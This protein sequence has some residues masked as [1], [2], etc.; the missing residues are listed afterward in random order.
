MEHFSKRKKGHI[1]LL[2]L[3]KK[4]KA[5]A[6]VPR[7][8]A[9]AHQGQEPVKPISKPPVTDLSE[10]LKQIWSVTIVDLL[11]NV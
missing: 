7:C 10:G 8:D 1:L 4:K 6:L 5:F 3:K 9:G 2:G 11:C